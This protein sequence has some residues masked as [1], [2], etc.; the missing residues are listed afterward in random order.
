MTKHED[1]QKPAVGSLFER[2]VGRL[3]PE[4]ADLP[5]IT[6]VA[7]HYDGRVWSLPAPNRH[8]DVIR[9]IASE[10]GDG[11]QGPNAQG[12]VD[13]AGRFLRRAQAYLLAARNGQLKRRPGGYQGTDLYSEDLW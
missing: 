7:V 13:D 3:E 2:G 1:A 6:H 8:H 4:R 12:F 5:R 11:I 9:H 10:T